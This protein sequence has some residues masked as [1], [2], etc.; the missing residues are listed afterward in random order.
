MRQI[1]SRSYEVPSLVK[2]RDAGLH[3]YTYFWTIDDK[4]VSPYFD[5]EES[6]NKWLS[7]QL[8]QLPQQSVSQPKQE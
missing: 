8:E 7:E 4:V 5:D 1:V 6:A 3:T 2:Y